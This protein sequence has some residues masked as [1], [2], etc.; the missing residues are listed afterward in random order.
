[1][2]GHALSC[3][4]TRLTKS[5]FDSVTVSCTN[6]LKE[7]Y[8]SNRIE[9]IKAYR[10]KPDFGDLDL[11]VESTG[12][13][14]FDASKALNATEIVR[15]GPVT[16]IGLKVNQSI[17]QVDLISM[18]PADFDSAMSYYSWNDLGN[19][20]GRLSHSMGVKLGFDGM[21]YAFKEGDYL[22][23]TIAIEKDWQKILPVLGLD[24]SRW[25]EGFD[26]LEDIFKFVATSKYFNKDIYLLHNRNHT[27]RV[28]DA[29]RKTYMDFLKWIEH[30]ELPSYPVTEDK[31]EWLPYLFENLTGFEDKYSEAQRDLAHA[32]LL[33]EK[34]NGKLVSK[35]TG[36]TDKQL[37]VFMQHLKPLTTDTWVEQSS[38][39]EIETLVVAEFN[40]FR[41]DNNHG[42]K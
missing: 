23:R 2:G 13:D 42:T 4:T 38:P 32:K 11:M 16:S 33:K 31:A 9:A 1:M 34:F 21:S 6:I 30:R 39:Q 20:I 5:D 22:F 29:K 17:F 3:E 41:K 15:N 8:P 18:A 27:A 40:K 14:P 35:L 36:L 19:L 26:T 10:A 28:R 37:G 24:Y 12:F 25:A 7:I